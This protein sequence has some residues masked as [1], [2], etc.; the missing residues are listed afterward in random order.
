MANP[1]HLKILKQGV[2][3]WNKWRAKNPDVMPDLREAERFRL[4]LRRANLSEA[5]LTGA[6]LGGALLVKADLNEA[7]LLGAKLNIARL[8]KADLSR[9][10][11]GGADL[12]EANLVDALLNSTCLEEADLESAILGNTILVNV[13]LSLTRGLDKCEHYAP[14]RIDHRTLEISENLPTAFL[15]GCGL[16]DSLIEW[17]RT[18]HKQPTQFYSAFI[19]YSSKNQDFADRLYAD[20]QNNGVRCWLATEDLKIG[21]PFRDVIDQA[22]RLRDKL[23][24]ILSKPA[25]QSE[26]VKDEV[27]AA[28]EEERKKRGRQILFPIRIDDGIMRTRK[29][30]AAKLRRQRHIGDFTNWKDHDEYQKAFDK[31]LR[32]LAAG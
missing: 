16:P 18:L 7:K 1:E 24:L 20:L 28:F 13:D 23:L 14:S 27:E 19:S 25:L 26:W 30:W 15:R 3:A 8:L 17:Y 32:D 12:R 21:D 22:I 5:D 11:I 9:A 31:L 6:D 2:G 10:C 29:A 4:D